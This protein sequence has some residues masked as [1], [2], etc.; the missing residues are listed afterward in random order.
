MYK[1]KKICVVVPAY[2]EGSQIAG[3]IETMPEYVD[4]VVVVDDA[5]I[6]DTVRVVK[7]CRQGRADL[8][9]IEHEKN[10][11]CGGAVI[12]GYAWAAERDFD[13]V[14]RMDG[15]GQMNPDDLT[16]LIDPVATGAVDFAKG[17][18]FFSGKAY[19]VMP[20]LRYLGTAFLSLLT[21]IVSGYWHLSDFQSGYVAIGRKALDTVDWQQMYTRYGQP[22]D[23]LILLNVYNFKVKDV[24]VDPVYHVG[25]VSGIKIKK[26]IFTLGWLLVKR[27]FWRLKEKYIIRDFHPLVFFYALGLS[28]GG[29]S[30]LLFLRVFFVWFTS[31]HIPTI[32]AFAAFSSFIA[33]A[34]FTLFAMWFDMEA[35]KHL[36][37]G[38]PDA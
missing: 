5:S 10:Q 34:Q 20:K 9:L 19:E 8:V 32:N 3:V 37:P 30:L 7:E 25:E 18:R 38:D 17:N 15:D 6:D 21:K 4:A 24:P 12:S 2:N 1:D 26:V 16:S 11:G 13:V 14:V 28:L 35:N 33:S 22:N 29:F 36:R 31:G 23:Q 27:F